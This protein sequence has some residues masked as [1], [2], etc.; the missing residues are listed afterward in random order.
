MIPNEG[1][2]EKKKNVINLV[3]NCAFDSFD[4]IK[5]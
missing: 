4:K 3:T 1:N 2:F 5:H